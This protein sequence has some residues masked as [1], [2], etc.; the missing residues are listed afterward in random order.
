MYFILEISVAHSKL[1]LTETY[2]VG[3]PQRHGDGTFSARVRGVPE[4]IMASNI[5]DKDQVDVQ[6]KTDVDSESGF[7]DVDSNEYTLRRE[8][9]NR[10]MAMIRYV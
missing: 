3:C 5:Q 10:H 4:T 2:K 6:L 8:L 7:S 1:V 9:K